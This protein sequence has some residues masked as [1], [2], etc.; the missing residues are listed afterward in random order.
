MD[1]NEITWDKE[2][3]NNTFQHQLNP[4]KQKFARRPSPT[5][6][7]VENRITYGLS[8]CVLP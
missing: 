8:V 2:G 3:Q 4:N 6:H 7:V 1:A 5:I